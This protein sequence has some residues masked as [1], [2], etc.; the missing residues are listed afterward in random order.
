MIVSYTSGDCSHD[1]ISLLPGDLVAEA[2][3]RRTA[4]K[5]VI[6]WKR[7]AAMAACLALFLGVGSRFI[8]QLAAGGAKKEAA[9]L[10]AAPEEDA[11]ISEEPIDK[12]KS[13][14]IERLH[15]VS[16]H[17]RKGIQTYCK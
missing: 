8:G 5:P 9:V 11:Y 2:D 4:P 7:Y 17:K 16:E 12:D 14:I 10:Q 15:K 13:A 6:P 1:A 3:N